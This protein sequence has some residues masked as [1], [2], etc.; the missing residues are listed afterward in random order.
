MTLGSGE[1]S[2]D[3]SMEV[4]S[5]QAGLASPN[6]MPA[7]LYKGGLL[8]VTALVAQCGPGPLVLE[9]LPLSCPHWFAMD[10]P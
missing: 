9:V 8:T 4:S 10:V 3:I 7:V 2:A 5:G 1:C 6:S